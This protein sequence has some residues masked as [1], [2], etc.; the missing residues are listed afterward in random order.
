[1]CRRAA[2]AAIP[3]RAGAAAGRH[4]RCRRVERGRLVAGRPHGRH[5]LRPAN[6]AL[7]RGLRNC[8][9]TG[10]VF[11]A[12]EK[13]CPVVSFLVGLVVLLVGGY[14]YGKFCE[15]VFAPD[16]RTTPAYAMADGVNFVP[17]KR[18]KR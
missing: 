10:S 4:G 12:R 14:L 8:Y 16:A 18:W 1:M 2:N 7:D 9:L 13:G 3:S 17:M 15:R 6:S 5:A 11:H